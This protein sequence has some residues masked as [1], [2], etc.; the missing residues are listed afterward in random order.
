KN[1]LEDNGRF[2]I[3]IGHKDTDN[4]L[5]ENEVR[6]NHEDGVFFR[7]ETEGMAGHR[8]RLERNIIE[9]NGGAQEASGIRVRGETHDLVFRDNI[10]RD[11]RPAGAQK[12][13]VG[14]RIEAGAGTVR[15]ENNQ[16]DAQTRIE[17]QRK[18]RP[19]S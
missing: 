5:E 8:N 9:N 13:T 2:G 17:D 6:G 10:I 14:I 15:L 18:L 4:L 7:N 3:S 19:G 16:I 12:Q 11:T 1:I